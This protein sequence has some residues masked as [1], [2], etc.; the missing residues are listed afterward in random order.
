M[1]DGANK[2][3]A[4]YSLFQVGDNASRYKLS[5]GGYSGNAGN[6]LGGQNGK[7]WSALD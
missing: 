7:K 2:N 5:V 4:F 3:Y 1:V 6:S